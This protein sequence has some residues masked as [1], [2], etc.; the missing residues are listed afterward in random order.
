LKYIYTLAEGPRD[1]SQWLTV[2]SDRDG[3]ICLGLDDLFVPG[4]LSSLEGILLPKEFIRWERNGRRIQ[5]TELGGYLQ[6]TSR[7][8]V[9]GLE[10]RGKGDNH[11]YRRDVPRPELLSVLTEYRDDP[12]RLR[13]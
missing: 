2:D 7:G 4:D 3:R 8:E 9:M 5:I 12:K 11:A 1:R 13:V 10:F 6:L